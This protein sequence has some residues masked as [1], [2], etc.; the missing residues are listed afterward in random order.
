MCHVVVQYTTRVTRILTGELVTV[1]AHQCIAVCHCEYVERYGT[2]N[3]ASILKW[4]IFLFF[5][6][7]I[8]ERKDFGKNKSSRKTSSI[9]EER[10]SNAGLLL[11]FLKKNEIR[12]GNSGNPSRKMVKIV[13]FVFVSLGNQKEQTK[14]QQIFTAN[15]ENSLGETGTLKSVGEL[16]LRLAGDGL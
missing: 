16:N 13:A 7:S 9:V 4:T 8:A 2:G 5:T 1:V 14:Q 10:L 6:F 12:S 11:L 15:A 3:W